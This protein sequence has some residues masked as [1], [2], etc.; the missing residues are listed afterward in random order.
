MNETSATIPKYLRTQVTYPFASV[1]RL[2]DMSDV[3]LMDPSNWDWENVATQPPKRARSVISVA[4]SGEQLDAVGE[5]AKRRGK[6]VS[7]FIRE[8]A[9]RAARRKR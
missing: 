5:A 1:Q 3:E 2:R 7:A 8:A 4:F 9:L 6:K